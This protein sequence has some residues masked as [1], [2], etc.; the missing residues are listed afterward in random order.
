MNRTGRLFLITFCLLLGSACIAKIGK[1]VST[2]NLAGTTEP[3]SPTKPIYPTEP[4]L[5]TEPVSLSSPTGPDEPVFISGEIPFTS[6]FFLA[7]TAEPFVMLEDEAGFVKRD[8]EFK[9][10]LQGQTIGPV[11][12]KDQ[13]LYYYLS[14]PEVPQGTMVDVDNNDQESAGVQVFVVAY[15]SNTWGDPFLEERDGKG[16][17]SAYTSAITDPQEDYE[18]TGGTLI[19]WAP[20]DKQGFSTDFGED[21]KLFTADDPTGPIPAGYNIVDLNVHP[22]RVYKEA[23][24]KIDLIE[25][26]GEVNDYSNLSYAEAFE[27]LFEK[28]SREYPF[29]KEKGID[30]KALQDEFL[31]QFEKVR[32]A[33]EFN[34]ALREFSYKIPDGHVGVSFN[35]EVFYEEHGG[36][37]GL[38]LVQLSD[39][40]VLVKEVLAG[41]PG[42]RE[43]IKEGAEIVAW[44][45]KPVKQAIDEV[46]PYFGPYSTQHAK[47]LAQV[48]FLTRVPPDTRVD[49]TYRN[50]GN[51]GEKEATLKAED[52]YDSL[53]RTFPN[54]A[55]DKLALPVEGSI[56]DE[57][58]LGYIRV[59]S[60]QDD[61]NMIAR[62]WDRYIQ[63][64]I[65]N[66]I[67]GL[68]IDLRVNSGGSGS[69]AMDFAGYFFDKEFTLHDNYYY[70]EISGN[71]EKNEY[72]TRI[73]PAPKIYNGPVTVLVSPDCISACEFFAY[74]LQYDG[75]SVVV[76]SYPTAGAAGEVGRGQYGLPDGISMQF[77]TGRP[78]T[79]DGKV[80]IEGTG[81][82]P[83]I[84]VPVTQES[85][86]GQA[87]TVLE[88][89]IKDLLGRL[90]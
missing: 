87:D 78:T 16:W 71:F 15:W 81:V 65:D 40:R 57:S 47:H 59:N 79:T 13:K 30:W 22:F 76:G 82:I 21:G 35:P 55:M 49:I 62:L 33:E 44:Q 83:D 19:V 3:V 52:E 50:P 68:I 28:A 53:Y 26:A 9:F 72:P 12:L 2:A 7:T 14:L 17:S 8:R 85:A 36:G 80:I 86:L 23:K 89:A 63:D 29:T 5:P 64:L 11:E 24:P 1:P 90:K 60:F 56:L 37:L 61:Y 67:P 66:E 84:T 73:K 41:K 25:G 51:T 48:S 32:S 69:L 74:A 38:V 43:G 27:K 34:T 31:P 39:G 6:P 77:P 88:A 4:V 70:N 42:D 10:S 18:I 46:I 45:G 20:D 54:F 75:R 58:G